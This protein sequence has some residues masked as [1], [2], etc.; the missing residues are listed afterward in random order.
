MTELLTGL[1][2]QPDFP[3]EDLSDTN[4]DLL[5]LM[6][7]NPDL[8]HLGH[9]E[10]EKM[11]WAFRVG[12]PAVVRGTSRLYDDDTYTEAVDHGVASFEAMAT[13]V[14]SEVTTDSFTVNANAVALASQLKE[15]KLQQY[16]DSA[17][18]S[19]RENTPR[20]AEVISLSARR[21]YGAL[22]SYAL[23]GAAL[24]R[25]FEIDASPEDS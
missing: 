23:L 6:L 22:S 24:A 16:I 4:A 20:A 18:D 10:G 19:F 21:F 1:T 25:Q 13:M 11:S 12:H 8:V 17:L 15:Y 2:P 9:L 3:R 7:A 5:E 14:G